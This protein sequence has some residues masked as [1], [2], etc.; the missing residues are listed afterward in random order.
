M[1]GQESFNYK[2]TPLKKKIFRRRIKTAIQGLVMLV[3]KMVN[4]TR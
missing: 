4:H 1:I 2:D 3:S